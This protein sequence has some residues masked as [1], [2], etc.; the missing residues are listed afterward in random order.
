MEDKRIEM[1]KIK[2]RRRGPDFLIKCINYTAAV[3]WILIF[4]VFIIVSVAKP[5]AG[6]YMGQSAYSRTWDTGLVQ[7]AFYLM[8]PILIMCTVGLLVNSTR[9]QRKSDTYN[10]TLVVS[11]VLSLIGIILF[12]IL[13]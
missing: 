13:M 9:H 6:S 10:K 3:I 7:Y 8:F 1:V 2:N 12:F 5:P 11:F 4:V